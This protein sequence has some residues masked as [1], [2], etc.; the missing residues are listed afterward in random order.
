MTS[1]APSPVAMEIRQS[2]PFPNF[3]QEAT[4]ALLRTAD[5]VR[6]RLA[7]TI[8]P[9]GITVQQYNVLRI[10]S[11]AGT[12][13]LPTLE[14]AER[15]IEQAPGIT[16]LLDRLEIKQFVVRERLAD[17]RRCVMCRIT[18]RGLDLL[19]AMDGDIASFDAN[20]T[21]GL[22]DPEL[23]RLLHLLA[24]IRAADADRPCPHQP[25]DSK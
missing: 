20:A 5:L 23:E 14:I 25:G 1:K 8:E 16:R 21:A 11:G 17:D 15:M 18:T 4:V 13:G 10:L 3:A 22:S 7:A 24:R 9:R 6:R 19:A 2:K 12:A